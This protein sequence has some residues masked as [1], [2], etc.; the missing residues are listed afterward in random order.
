M[1]KIIIGIHGLGNKPSREL[2]E[3]WW[4]ASIDEGLQH[5]GKSQI[6]YDFELIYWADILNPKSLDEN[7]TDKDSKFFINEKYTPAS[8]D[9]IPYKVEPNSIIDQI[10]FSQFDKIFVDPSFNKNHEVISEFLVKMYFREMS[11]YYSEEEEYKDYRN[12][13]MYR[14]LAVLKKYEKNEIFLIAHSM[15]SIIIYDILTKLAPKLKIKILITIGSPLGLPIIVEKNKAFQKIKTNPQTPEGV[16]EWINF[17]DKED[18]IAVKSELADYYSPNKKGVVPKFI[19]VTNNYE[20]NNHRNPHKSYGYLRAK[21]FSEVLYKFLTKDITQFDLW[22]VK[23]AG[24]IKK[25]FKK[26]LG[27]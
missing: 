20:I 4:K 9:F 15:G 12:I 23:A 7:I 21:Q 3:K 1:S 6:K 25:F 11:I 22:K 5:I 27:T 8:K 26:F 16:L 2:L 10:I 24:N 18:K 19:E 14:I 17:A 13:I